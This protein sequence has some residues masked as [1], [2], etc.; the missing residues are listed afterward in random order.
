MRAASAAA[1]SYIRLPAVS[2][3]APRIASDLLVPS[4]IKR[5]SARD[6]SSSSRSEIARSGMSNLVS[7]LSYTSKSSIQSKSCNEWK[8]ASRHA[9]V[10]TLQRVVAGSSP[11][12]SRPPRP[13]AARSHGGRA[14]SAPACGRPRTARWRR[15]EAPRPRTRA[16]GILLRVD[17]PFPLRVSHGRLE[18]REPVVEE[19]DEPIANRTGLHVDL[20]QHR[21]EEAAAREIVDLDVAQV[22]ASS[23]RRRSRPEAAS[24]PAR[25]PARRTASSPSRPSRAGAPP[26]SRSA[27]TGRSCSSRPRRPA[28]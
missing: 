25:S 26:S 3:T 18:P 7:H 10:P 5:D 8:Q 21:R 22:A 20:G 24:T 9:C 23:T 4:C 27:R 15:A 19:Q 17:R 1:S 2:T 28:G 16:D 12:A 6:A 14:R 13:A 11:T